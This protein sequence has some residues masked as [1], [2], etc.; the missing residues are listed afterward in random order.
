MNIKK[1]FYRPVSPLHNEESPKGSPFGQVIALLIILTV[2]M[3]V[4]WKVDPNLADVFVNKV[5]AFSVFLV[6]A[7]IYGKK[8]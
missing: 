2:V 8:Q 6:S 3:I 4:L 5:P 1:G 7:R